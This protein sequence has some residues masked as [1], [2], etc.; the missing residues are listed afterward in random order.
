ML[1]LQRYIIR[2]FCM[3]ALQCTLWLVLICTLLEIMVQLNAIRG[4]YQ[5]IQVLQYV[6]L[7][8]PS[9]IQLLAPLIGL[10]A[11]A[12]WVHQWIITQE[13]LALR[14]L[15][16]SIEQILIAVLLAS[17]INVSVLYGVGEGLAPKATFK[18]KRLRAKAQGQVL[19][20]DHGLWWWS[21]DPHLTILNYVQH[22]QSPKR[23]KGVIQIIRPENAPFVTRVI[24]APEAYFQ[25]GHW[26]LSQPKDWSVQSDRL[27]QT[28][29][30]RVHWPLDPNLVELTMRS[31]RMMSLFQVYKQF[32]FAQDFKP[33]EM[34][35][36]AYHFFHR[37]YAPLLSLLLSCLPAVFALRYLRS[38]GSQLTVLYAMV[39]GLCIYLLDTFMAPI[40]MTFESSIKMW[41]SMPL[42]VLSLMILSLWVKR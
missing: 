3:I 1:Q 41:A 7:M 32:R 28:D 2:S 22:V 25:K 19:V 8:L 13:W 42:I 37:L 20:T 34:A 11:G 31:D 5:F 15:G 30:A 29:H 38:R 6:G 14:V 9:R 24:T 10:L 23:L 18:A 12:L 40:V 26:F 21:H 33:S 16:Y 39:L 4:N 35:S 17:L 36:H 27:I